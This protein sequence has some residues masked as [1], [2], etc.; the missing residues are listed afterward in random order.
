M[1]FF[2]NPEVAER[3]RVIRDHGMSKS[4]KYWHLVVG[5]NYRLTNLQAA[6]GLGQV[7]R[8]EEIVAA[9]KQ[10]A[11]LYAQKLQGFSDVKMMPKSRFGESSFWLVA[12]S[13]PAFAAAKREVL[14]EALAA[15]GVQSRTVFPT[16]HSMPAFNPFPKATA[17]GQAEIIARHGLCLPSTP[18]MDE[19]AVTRVVD[20]L[21]RNLDLL[22]SHV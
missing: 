15:D 13:L 3:A 16:L 18:S 1:T 22:G 20:S 6:I 17:M 5:G 21:G 14:M 4:R 11:S 19:A 9:K 8:A 12:V 10:V 2:S 7:E